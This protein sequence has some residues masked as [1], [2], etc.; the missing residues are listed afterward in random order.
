MPLDGRSLDRMC[1]GRDAG[2]VGGRTRRWGT[3]WSPE[4]IRRRLRIDFPDDES[5]RISHEATYQVLYIQGRGA[6]RRDLTA[7]LR[8]GRALTVPRVRTRG[9]KKNFV[10]SEVMTSERP[11]EV[12]DRAVSGHSTSSAPSWRFGQRNELVVMHPLQCSGDAA[13][14]LSSRG[15][16][17]LPP[18]PAALARAVAGYQEA[19]AATEDEA[20]PPGP[21]CT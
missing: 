9:R 12:E 16:R 2:T 19:A 21:S 17:G 7:C 8:T 4:Q 20:A 10:T 15:D 1:H 18:A 14:A 11:A 13:S 5:M 3:A 6:L